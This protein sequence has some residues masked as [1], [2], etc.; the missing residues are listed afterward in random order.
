MAGRIAREL[1]ALSAAA[2]VGLAAGGSQTTRAED[3]ADG[4]PPAPPADGGARAADGGAARDSDQEVI[5]HLDELEKLELLQHLGL[6][7]PSGEDDAPAAPP[8]RASP[9]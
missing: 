3:H 7:D 6:L 5:D 1:A 2:C 9:R 8:A 4:G